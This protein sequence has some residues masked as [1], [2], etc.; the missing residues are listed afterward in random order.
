[1]FDL[2]N[3]RIN[4]LR[5]FLT[6]IIIFFTLI[7]FGISPFQ[8][9]ESIIYGSLGSLPKLIRT[10]IVWTPISLASLLR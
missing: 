5:L 7:L 2:Y 4:L 8:V 10:L 1:M 3:L 6:L 9:F